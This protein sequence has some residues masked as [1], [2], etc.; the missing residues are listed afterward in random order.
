MGGF[1]LRCKDVERNEFKKLLL[2][3]YQPE[4]ALDQFQGDQ[5]P[6]DQPSDSDWIGV[7][8]AQ[9]FIHLLEN[10]RIK[11]PKISEET[12]KDRDKRDAFLRFFTIVQLVW[13]IVQIIARRSNELEITPIETTTLALVTNSIFIYCFWWSK[14][15]DVTTAE[16]LSLISPIGANLNS[17]CASAADNDTACTEPGSGT[18]CA[19]LASESSSRSVGNINTHPSIYTDSSRYSIFVLSALL[20]IPLPGS[21][22]VMAL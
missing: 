3:H 16:T 1:R 10:K 9:A 22:S 20:E 19:P 5:T 15:F 8:T 12:L 11:Y 17:G 14:P 18:G 13:F 6:D 7:L 21:S 2:F 4:A